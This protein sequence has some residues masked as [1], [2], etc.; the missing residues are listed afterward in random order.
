V[1]VPQ[2]KAPESSRIE[3]AISSK[4]SAS[5]LDIQKKRMALKEHLGK[6]LASL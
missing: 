4:P 2:A 1:I 5:G 3:V 6:L